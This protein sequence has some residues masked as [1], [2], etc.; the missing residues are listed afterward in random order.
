MS[1]LRVG[2]IEIDGSNITIGGVPQIPTAPKPGAIAPGTT[3]LVTTTPG[4]TALVTTTPATAALVTTTPGALAPRSPE[5]LDALASFPIGHRL[6]VGAGSGLAVAAA[7]LLATTEAVAAVPLLFSGIGGVVVGILK[8]R[9]LRRRDAAQARSQE[10]EL[11]EHAAR[12]RPLLAEARPEQTIEWIVEKSGLPEVT[13]VRTLAFMR[14]RHDVTE[15]LNTETGEWYYGATLS[16]P[17]ATRHLDER[18][19]ALEQGDRKP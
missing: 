11:G 5:G 19:A 8:R 16:L 18:L 6:L 14:D 15:E 10:R 1:R 17:P 12:L 7:A 13:V 9:A 4:T 3:A 2:D